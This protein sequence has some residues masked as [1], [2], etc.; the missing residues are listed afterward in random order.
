MPGAKQLSV[1]AGPAKNGFRRPRE[2]GDLTDMDEKRLYPWMCHPLRPGEVITGLSL[3][4][5][6][7][8]KRAVQPALAPTTYVEIGLWAIP[9]SVLGQGFLDLI[10]ASAEDGAEVANELVES[11]TIPSL[12]AGTDLAGVLTNANNPVHGEIGSSEV[13]PGAE[14]LYMPY[15]SRANW[16]VAGT[17]YDLEWNDSGQIFRNDPDRFLEAPQVSNFIE[18]APNAGIDVAQ[19]ADS[20]TTATNSVTEMIERLSLLTK[21]ER[22]YADYLAAFGIDPRSVMSI[23]HPLLLE[24]RVLRP[25]GIN[26]PNAAAG[27]TFVESALDTDTFVGTNGEIV[28]D[29]GGVCMLHSTLNRFRVRNYMAREPS[30]IL[31]TA[32]WYGLN[33]AASQYTHYMDISLMTSGAHWGDVSFGGVD[34][35]DF[36]N[37]AAMRTQDGSTAQAGTDGQ[38]S[39]LAMNMLNLFIN[40]SHYANDI[41]AIEYRTIRGQEL[42]AGNQKVIS[43]LSAQFHILTDMVG[44]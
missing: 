4:G 44:G 37:V 30:V 7:W 29:Q 41:A 43:K 13:T 40:G 19:E 6:A 35:T 22:T 5:E 33:A 26:F 39:T 24:Q 28:L 9:L 23:P 34:E 12:D 11:G 27:A 42:S 16:A 32:V 10:V 36:L 8:F 21:T 1:G 15:V 18:S 2:K 20:T 14:T 31:G 25:I 17:W 3:Q 38:G